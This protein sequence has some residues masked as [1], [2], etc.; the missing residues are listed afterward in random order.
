[1]INIYE[2]LKSFQFEQREKV[3]KLTITT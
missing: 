2:V 3:M 1:M